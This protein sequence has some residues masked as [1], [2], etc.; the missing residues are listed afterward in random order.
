MARRICLLLLSVLLLAAAVPPAQGAA[1]GKQAQRDAAASDSCSNSARSTTGVTQ[2]TVCPAVVEAGHA[3]QFAIRS[4]PNQSV[5]VVLLYPNGVIDR[6]TSMTDAQ[7]TATVD[8]VVH[9]HPLYRYGQAKFQVTVGPLN[10]A[11]N[12]VIS[13]VVNIAQSTSSGKPRLRVRPAGARN[14]C[15]ENGRCTVRDNTSIQIRVDTDPD[16]Q[17]Q[18]ALSYPNGVTLACPGN[19]LTGGAGALADDSGA[20][21]CQMPVYYNLANAKAT[22]TVLVQVTVTTSS[23]DTIP[24]QYKLWLKK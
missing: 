2:V 9:Y 19:A 20:F 16:A 3:L 8:I 12:E 7:G 6:Q 10:G 14:W 23:G 15:A 17:V 4:R 24:I 13:G 11:D 5:T 1:I 18:L 22:V 21:L